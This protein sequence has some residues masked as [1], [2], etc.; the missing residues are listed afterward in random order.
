MA[1][2]TAI[3][4]GGDWHDASAEY[5]VLPD[6]VDIAAEHAAWRAWYE[7]E[8]CPGLRGG[9]RVEYVDLVQWL[10]RKGAREPGD[11]ELHVFYDA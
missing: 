4:G 7:T 2:I 6:G 8:Y 5:L 1:K 9:A 3:H 11:G 10:K